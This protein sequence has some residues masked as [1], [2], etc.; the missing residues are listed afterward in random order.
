[1]RYRR[2]SESIYTVIEWLCAVY[3]NVVR[4][5]FAHLPRNENKKKLLQQFLHTETDATNEIGPV[6]GTSFYIVMMCQ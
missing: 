1:M 2:G 4:S 5:G 3:L 6:I